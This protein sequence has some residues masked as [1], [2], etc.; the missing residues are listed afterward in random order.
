MIR[1]MITPSIVQ[2]ENSI[3]M[4]FLNVLFLILLNTGV[5]GKVQRVQHATI[6]HGHYAQPLQVYSWV[7]VHAKIEPQVELQARMT[8]SWGVEVIGIKVRCFEP[9]PPRQEIRAGTRRLYRKNVTL[10]PG[11]GR[12]ISTPINEVPVQYIHPT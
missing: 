3:P 5:V 6:C 10:K 11:R 7:Y 4:A 1:F 9:S 12:K 8:L 2:Q